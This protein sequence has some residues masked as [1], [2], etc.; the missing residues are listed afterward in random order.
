MAFDLGMSMQPRDL[1]SADWFKET[2]KTLE[3]LQ[4]NVVQEEADRKAKEREPF[5]EKLKVPL[6]KL[7]Q[8][9][10]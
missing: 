10:L 1:S 2:K 6:E 5:V 8:A 4:R 9:S 3:E 7:K